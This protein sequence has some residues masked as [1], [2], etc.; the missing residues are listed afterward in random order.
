MTD[1]NEDVDPLRELLV[2]EEELTRT[3]LAA[4][5]RPYV[6][7]TENGQLMPTAEFDRLSALA[8]AACVLLAFRAQ[9]AL[10]IRET[11][12]ASPSDV[13]AA[14]GMPGG[15]VRPKLSQLVNDRLAIRSRDGYEIP[16]H[17]MRRTAE[18]I[19]RN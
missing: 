7:M 2:N 3:D 19:G 5:L 15:T 4:A 9:H 17:A 6:R 12:T 14:S 13:E 18:L 11:S 1:V 16:L 10:G 8:R